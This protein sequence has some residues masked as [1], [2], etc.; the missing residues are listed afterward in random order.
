[1]VPIQPAG[2]P[3]FAPEPPPF[4]RIP[5]RRR[6]G[7]LEG[8]ALVS[9]E[10][11]HKVR[12]H[13]WYANSNGYASRQENIPGTKKQRTVL[14]ARVILD[15]DFG[16]KRKVDHVSRDKLDNRRGNI[17]I[18]THAQNMQNQGSRRGSSRFRGVSFDKSRKTRPW[19]AYCCIDGKTR[20][21]GAYATEEEAGKVAADYR[22][23]HM[24]FSVEDAAA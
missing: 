15:L 5:L 13:R 8:H 2:A 4:V 9:A 3:A 10:D 22:R 21:L 19:I 24:P 16:D 18:A 17:R 14:M 1:M 23:E 7:S 11:A 20:Y 6:D 12:D